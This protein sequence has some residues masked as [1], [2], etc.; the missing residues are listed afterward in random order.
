MNGRIKSRPYP[1]P[2]I[3]ISE[4]ISPRPPHTPTASEPEVLCDLDEDPVRALERFFVL[5]N[6]TPTRSVNNDTPNKKQYAFKGLNVID[7]G[8]QFFGSIPKE[9]LFSRF[10]ELYAAIPDYLSNERQNVLYREGLTHAQFFFKTFLLFCRSLNPKTSVRKNNTANTVFKPCIS[11]TE[12]QTDGFMRML[13]RIEFPFRCKVWSLIASS[14]IMCVFGNQK[15]EAAILEAK[16]SKEVTFCALSF[17][18]HRYGSAFNTETDLQTLLLLGK[19]SGQFVED[20][21]GKRSDGAREL[22]RQALNEAE[23]WGLDEELFLMAR[24]RLCDEKKQ[25]V[26]RFEEF[27]H[28]MGDLMCELRK[29][30]PRCNQISKPWAYVAFSKALQKRYGTGEWG[31]EH[32][33]DLIYCLLKQRPEMRAHVVKELRERCS[34]PKAAS[35]WQHFDFTQDS[36][37]QRMQKLA[38][39]LENRQR[40]QAMEIDHLRLPVGVDVF[41]VDN[42]FKLACIE[43]NLRSAQ[44]N[45]KYSVIVGLDAEWSAYVLTSR[46]SIIQI[47]FEKT[48]CLVDL[49]QIDD[50]GALTDFMNRLFLDEKILKIGFRFGEDLV[51]IRRRLPSCNSLYEPESL[52]C[53]ARIIEELIRITLSRGLNPENFINLERADERIEGDEKEAI[54]PAE[55]SVVL[56][57]ED[58]DTPPP[59]PND[60][61]KPKEEGSSIKNL[62]LSALCTALLGFDLDKTEQCS[63]W[64]RRPLRRSQIQYAALDAYAMLMLF[65]VCRQ[66]ATQLGESIDDIID[67]Q[68]PYRIPLPLLFDKTQLQSYKDRQAHQSKAWDEAE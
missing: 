9:S 60:K 10:M 46:A 28:N 58:E 42:A 64:D 63:V 20:F 15:L 48:V 57:V 66:W 22:A 36:E 37:R 47:A 51:Q 30:M 27:S 26:L 12:E 40:K 8:R 54:I 23:K 49:D 24:K 32:L 56:D 52:V 13:A 11:M 1:P 21:L 44:S 3:Q 67:K 2:G 41:V 35:F 45:G 53:I 5:G 55:T 6:S 62:G 25:R 29:E 17:A 65:E 61:E 16:N 14:R 33:Y 34:D 31:I 4:F 18:L 50:H 59:T 39:N 7:I 38:T 68:E 43:H 19:A